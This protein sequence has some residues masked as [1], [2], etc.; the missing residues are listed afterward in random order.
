[1]STTAE[2]SIFTLK[3]MVNS[4]TALIAAR[5]LTS[6]DFLKAWAYDAA[7]DHRPQFQNRDNV[8]Y[9]LSSLTEHSTV[10]HQVQAMLWQWNPTF[11]YRLPGVV[12][13]I[14]EKDEHR[15]ALERFTEMNHAA[16]VREMLDHPF[17]GARMRFEVAQD[18]YFLGFLPEEERWQRLEAA[19]C[20]FGT[21]IN[22]HWPA[23]TTSWSEER[24]RR[25]VRRLIQDPELAGGFLIGERAHIGWH[26]FWNLEEFL[27]VIREAA[28]R[29]PYEATLNRQWIATCIGDRK[30]NQETFMMQE[31]EGDGRWCGWW[32]NPDSVHREFGPKGEAEAIEIIDASWWSAI[33]GGRT[34]LSRPSQAIAKRIET[35]NL[36]PEKA[37]IQGRY[38]AE[39]LLNFPDCTFSREILDRLCKAFGDEKLGH[40]YRWMLCAEYR[41]NRALLYVLGEGDACERLTHGDEQVQ[42]SWFEAAMRKYMEAKGWQFRTV[43]LRRND[44]YREDSDRGY[45]PQVKIADGRVTRVYALWRGQTQ[46]SDFI[47]SRPPAKNQKPQEVM[48]P[49]GFNPGEPHHR[50]ERGTFF[51]YRIGDK[52]LLADRWDHDYR[53][54]FG[55]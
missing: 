52:L 10:G 27:E 25:L 7:I 40:V 47:R 5:K 36:K 19:V 53:K 43:E 48:I 26:A 35:L 51:F 44:R 39:V 6:E 50:N 32:M 4:L 1:M 54:A 42:G 28:S 31:E 8:P 46:Y 33:T 37:P 3:N 16:F 38:V 29:A 15:R 24:T 34:K 30:T 18:P 21:A 41:F 20:E 17:F 13:W 12:S 23:Y 55:L 22:W 45:D 9:G 2:N 11:G 14:R 49:P